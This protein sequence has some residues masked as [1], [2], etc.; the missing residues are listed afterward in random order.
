MNTSL[1]DI[2]NWIGQNGPTSFVIG[3]FLLIFISATY[4]L[5]VRITRAITGKY[6]PPVPE[7][8]C[9]CSETCDYHE[10]ND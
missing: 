4:S 10:D 2:L 3:I 5:I 6:P 1:M 7:V 8:D 9:P